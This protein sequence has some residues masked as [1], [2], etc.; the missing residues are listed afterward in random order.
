VLRQVLVWSA[1]P[2]CLAVALL[3]KSVYDLPWANV[4]VLSPAIVIGTAAV[5]GMTLLLARAF[6]ANVHGREEG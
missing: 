5:V 1:L 6:W 2:L 4:I 3:L